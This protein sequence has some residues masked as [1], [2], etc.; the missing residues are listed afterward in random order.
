MILLTEKIGQGPTRRCDSRCYN[1]QGGQCKCICGGRNHGAGIDKALENV[2]TLFAPIVLCEHGKVI[3]A[4]EQGCTK[5]QGKVGEVEV[6]RR[7][8]REMRHRAFEFQ[9][10]ETNAN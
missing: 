6:T 4:C 8:L 9:P 1:A 5:A 10:G 3:G 2:R 7:A